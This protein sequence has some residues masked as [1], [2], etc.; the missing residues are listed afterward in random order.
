MEKEALKELLGQLSLEEKVMQLVQVPGSAF[1]KEA[2]ITGTMQEGDLERQKKLCGSTLGIQGAA[3]I[4]K[5]QE[6]YIAAHPH[7]IPLA[8]MLDVIHGYHTVFP[9]PLA[10]AASFDPDLAREAARVQKEEAMADGTHVTF[11]PM[12]DLVRDA[13]WG[14]VMESPGE[15]PLLG[16]RMAAAMVEGYQGEDLKTGLASCVKHFAAYG[17]PVAGR[18]YNNVE[19]SEHTLRDMY[20]PGYEEALRSGAALVMSAF[21]SWNGLPCTANPYLLKEILR[22]EMGFDG[23]LISDWNAI[24]ELV[25][26]GVA[27]D[28]KEAAALAFEAGVDIDMCSGSYAGHLRELVEEGRISEEALDEA[29]LRVLTLKNELGLFEDPTHGADEALA[30]EQSL[31]AAHQELARRAVQECV[32]LLKNEG[33]VLPLTDQRLALIGPYASE[34]AL[35]SFWAF[36]GPVEAVV[37]LEEGARACFE[38][39]GTQVRVAKG[40]EILDDQDATFAGVFESQE[41]GG[42]LLEEAIQVAE[43]ADTLILCLGEPAYYTGESTSRASLTLPGGQLSLLRRM[44]KTGKKIVTLIF[45]GRPLELREVSELSDALLYCY[46]P[47]TQGGNGIF[48]VLSGKVSPS[49]KLSMSLPWTTGQAPVSYNAF[50]TGRPKPAQGPSMFTTRYLDCPN[51]PL[52]PFGYGLTYG[53][54]EVSDIR[55]SRDTLQAGEEIL[56]T[57][58]LTNRGSVGVTEVAQ[59]YIRDEVASRVRPVKEL[60]DFV[61]VT[62]AAGESRE[63][64][65]AIR[66]EML[67]FEMGNGR[68]ESE[69]GTFMVYLG[70]SSRVDEGLRFTLI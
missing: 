6:D 1:E 30:K 9:L 65:F 54:V 48:D 61:R 33:E 19:L 35:N 21:H 49:G 15:D 62:L 51:E 55:L 43:E 40:C 18:D 36:T 52:Y 37:S 12:A 2:A 69:K 29:V 31:S 45:S 28:L 67:R 70:L 39:T 66:E 14:R 46:L 16:G 25:P 41:D 34:K 23:V 68:K 50:G 10:L 22:K 26:Q 59:L 8:F 7:H 3:K 13:R 4:R 11:S 58:T 64:S 53:R 17:A 63:V 42:A 24:G 5:I 60:K 44:K 20:L 47:G 38:G 32:V 27:A 57:A 56:A